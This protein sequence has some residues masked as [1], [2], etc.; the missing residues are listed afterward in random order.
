MFNLNIYLKK[1]SNIVRNGY[2][3]K[4]YLKF[5]NLNHYSYMVFDFFYYINNINH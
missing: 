1:F 4:H 2:E 5:Y 3:R